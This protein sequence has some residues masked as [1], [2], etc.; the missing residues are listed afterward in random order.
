MQNAGPGTKKAQKAIYISTLYSDELVKRKKS[1]AVGLIYKL[2]T[3]LGAFG[4]LS[5]PL[6]ALSESPLLPLKISKVTQI[7]L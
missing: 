5:I 3:F 7:A 1:G 2:I 6:S 4:T